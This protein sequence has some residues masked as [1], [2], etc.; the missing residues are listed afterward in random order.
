MS[1]QMDDLPI[2]I[3][4]SGVTDRPAVFRVV[5]G[6]EGRVNTRVGGRHSQII[7]VEA[8]GDFVLRSGTRAVCL[9]QVSDDDQILSR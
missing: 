3:L 8:L 5:D 2:C 7:I 1:I 9:K 4:H 6:T